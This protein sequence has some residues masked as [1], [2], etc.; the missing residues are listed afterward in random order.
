MINLTNFL[1]IHLVLDLNFTKIL[2][3][4]NLVGLSY[5]VSSTSM[6][7]ETKLFSIVS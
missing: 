3:G 2:R 7:I 5:N 4:T 6:H 1:K